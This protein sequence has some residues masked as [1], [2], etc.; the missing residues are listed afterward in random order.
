MYVCM[1]VCIILPHFENANYINTGYFC[2][3]LEASTGPD[4]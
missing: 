1:Y 2:V 3:F 4:M